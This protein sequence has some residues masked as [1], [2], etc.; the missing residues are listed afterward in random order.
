MSAWNFMNYASKGNLLEAVRR[1]AA[2]MFA[3]AE[4]PEIWM[5][6]T[7]A[8]DWQVREWAAISTA[9]LRRIE[10]DQV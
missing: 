9:I 1:E 2:G 10:A 5:A 3:L 6:P 7:A 8:G 4:E